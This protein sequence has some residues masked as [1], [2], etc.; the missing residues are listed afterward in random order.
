MR[1][2]N[3]FKRYNGIKFKLK[4]SKEIIEIPKIIN[5]E[6]KM[7]FYE[8]SNNELC[9]T[10]EH[11]LNVG[12]KK[13]SYALSKVYYKDT[14]IHFS[15]HSVALSKLSEK[16]YI[17]SHFFTTIKRF[18][19]LNSDDLS[20]ISD[21]FRNIVFRENYNLLNFDIIDTNESSQYYFRYT[22]SSK[23]EANQ[24]KLD[25]DISH[26]IS[27]DHS[28]FFNTLSYGFYNR[29]DDDGKLKTKKI[30]NFCDLTKEL[31]DFNPFPKKNNLSIIESKTNCS[32]MP[33]TSNS[34]QWSQYFI[35]SDLEQD[36]SLFAL[37][38]KHNDFNINYNNRLFKMF[39][40]VDFKNKSM[41]LDLLEYK[42]GQFVSKK[43][44]PIDYHF[45]DDGINNSY[46]LE[47]FNELVQYIAIK[48]YP[49]KELLDM[50]GES[51]FKEELTEDQCNVIKMILY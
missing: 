39:W 14:L 6:L 20:N 48:Y 3:I 21:Y 31:I 29:D 11:N 9:F 28:L 34:S 27:Y 36:R 44:I 12:N 2:L 25:F 38:I 47:Y 51:N 50:I 32:I 40:I 41:L 45:T 35:M 1:F 46:Y 19:E 5:N 43:N 16:D 17:K 42:N 13:S 22:V 49:K 24:Y 10:F 4:K 8:Y 37:S 7:C 18:N 33:M 30:S 15:R 26:L 23:G